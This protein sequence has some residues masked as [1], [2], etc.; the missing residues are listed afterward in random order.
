MK[1][2]ILIFFLGLFSVSVSFSQQDTLPLE[3]DIFYQMPSYIETGSV[4]FRHM[5]DTFRYLPDYKSGD[6]ISDE[7]NFVKAGLLQTKISYYLK[8]KDKNSFFKEFGNYA[9]LNKQMKFPIDPSAEARLKKN[10]NNK[11][12]VFEILSEIE[13]VR[14][15]LIEDNMNLGGKK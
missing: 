8:R 5:P 10:W 3:T 6:I 9:E 14:T 13:F 4:F 7:M 2:H 11:D 1:H 15:A 12:S